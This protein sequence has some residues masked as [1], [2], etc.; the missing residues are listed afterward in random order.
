MGVYLNFQIYSH[1]TL[2]IFSDVRQSFCCFATDE[3]CWPSWRDTSVL[4]EQSK[5]KRNNQ[6]SLQ[7]FSVYK[8]RKE[9]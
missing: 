2:N 3:I 1:E 4:A 7:T 5:S 8:Q 9:N 6:I